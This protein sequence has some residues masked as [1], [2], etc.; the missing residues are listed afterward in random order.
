MNIAILSTRISGIDGVSL[1]AE[2][3]REVLLSMGHNVTFIAGQLDRYGL[4]IPEL[5][6]QH[7]K[8]V[9]L[10]QNI[11]YSRGGYKDIEAELFDLSGTIE[12]K[13]REIFHRV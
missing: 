12:G 10:Y 2:R 8:V 11:V 13:L 6:F 5:H 4:L 3:W 1:E 9:N 7:P